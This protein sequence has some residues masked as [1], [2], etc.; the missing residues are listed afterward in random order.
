MTVGSTT[1]DA[2]VLLVHHHLCV[3]SFLLLLPLELGREIGTVF[4][5]NITTT[6][7]AYAVKALLSTLNFLATPPLSSIPTRTLFLPHPPQ[8]HKEDGMVDTKH[9]TCLHPGCTR[10]PSKSGAVATTKSQP[11]EENRETAAGGAA[12]TAAARPGPARYCAAHAPAGAANVTASR[13]RHPG[14]CSVQP[15]FG[16][17]GGGQQP[18]FCALHRKPGMTDVRNPRS[19]RNAFGFGL[20]CGACIYVRALLWM[21]RRFGCSFPPFVRRWYGRQGDTRAPSL[22]T[23][24]SGGA[25]R[26]WQRGTQYTR[27]LFLFSS[28]TV[29]VFAYC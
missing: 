8:E 15:Y 7:A 28:P 17:E 10:F 4:T 14:G 12:A 16:R 29:P 25:P 6:I 21:A 27:F 26:H 5:V 24:P 18:E 23:C 11:S 22:F 1:V 9:K 2:A 3:N 20:T 19:V 13:C